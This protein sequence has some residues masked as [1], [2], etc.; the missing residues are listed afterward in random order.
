MKRLKKCFKFPFEFRYKLD[1][2][3]PHIPELSKKQRNAAV[4]KQREA[5]GIEE[6]RGGRGQLL[7]LMYT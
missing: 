7:L 1:R 5:G 2:A 4:S 3:R 6:L